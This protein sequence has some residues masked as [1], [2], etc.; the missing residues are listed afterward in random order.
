MRSLGL[1]CILLFTSAKAQQFVPDLQ[2]GVD[3]I[4]FHQGPAEIT[5]AWPVELMSLPNGKY[6]MASS[7]SNNG[8]MVSRHLLNGNRD[9]SFALN[10]VW[11]MN[12]NQDQI[13][14]LRAMAV[15][16][17]GRIVVLFVQ[18]SP[19]SDQRTALILRVLPDGQPDPTFNMNGEVQMALPDLAELRS[20]LIGPD[21]GLVLVGTTNGSVLAVRLEADGQLD[22]AFGTDGISINAASLGPVGLN[23]AKFGPDGA[24]FVAGSLTN[25][26]D[27]T[28]SV[29]CK[30]LPSGGV[31]PNFGTDGFFVHDHEENVFLH[32]S[33]VDLW[34]AADGSVIA[35]GQLSLEG[36]KERFHAL[37]LDP[38]GALDPDFADGGM[39][40]SGTAPTD[41]NFLMDL[42]Y[43]ERGFFVLHGVISVQGVQNRSLFLLMNG[44]GEVL[45]D[46]TGES[47]RILSSP[48]VPRFP[49]RMVPDQEGGFIQAMGY[50]QRPIGRTS[51]SRFQLSWSLGTMTLPVNSADRLHTW[52]NPTNGTLR[53]DLTEPFQQQP[54]ITMLDPLGRMVADQSALHW[55]FTGDHSIALEL[56][57]TIAEGRYS[58]VMATGNERRMAHIVV[59]R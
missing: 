43:D 6:L 28:G 29:V 9:S 35:A 45:P 41:R 50:F 55:S 14:M 26:L 17:D 30:L 24:I 46:D 44:Q 57:N 40:I 38:N 42:L 7:T 10:G 21:G 16:S 2:F 53:I 25:G 11:S 13:R 8:S 4:N 5:S 22:H 27:A 20:I 54:T 36:I 15:G 33:L 56:P 12:S 58:L 34:P 49:R 37:K 51:L 59:Q 47:F 19:G 18:Y 3:G 23:K 32:E 52:P 31:D 1:F 48:D 39:L